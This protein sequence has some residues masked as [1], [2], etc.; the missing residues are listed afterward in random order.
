MNVTPK[1]FENVF[2]SF[3]NVEK[4]IDPLHLLFLLYDDFVVSTVLL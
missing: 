2:Q 1:L 4:R 3:Y